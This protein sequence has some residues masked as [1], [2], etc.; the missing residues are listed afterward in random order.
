MGKT[1][2]PVVG[3]EKRR[4]SISEIL[5]KRSRGMTERSAE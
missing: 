4:L 3:G 5:D 1:A 2:V